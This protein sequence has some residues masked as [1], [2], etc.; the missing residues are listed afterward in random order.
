MPFY[1]NIVYQN[2]DEIKASR[3]FLYLFSRI[4][5]ELFRTG[6][7]FVSNPVENGIGW[8]RPIVKLNKIL[9]MTKDAPLVAYLSFPAKFCYPK[10][11]MPKT[12]TEIIKPIWLNYSTARR[13][14]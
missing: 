11:G 2:C 7:S 10:Q 6:T 8:K 12:C 5:W 4:S 1:L 3:F 14:I 13:V 9:N